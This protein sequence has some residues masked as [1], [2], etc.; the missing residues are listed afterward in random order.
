[1]SAI[2]KGSYCPKYK[3]K[4]FDLALSEEMSKFLQHCQLE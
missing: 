2:E 1:M 3:N 4:E